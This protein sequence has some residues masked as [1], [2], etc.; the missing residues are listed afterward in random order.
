M[1]I[2]I[3]AACWAVVCVACQRDE[4][5]S[6]LHAWFVGLIA[7]GEKTV[8]KQKAWPVCCFARAS[9]SAQSV[10]EGLPKHVISQRGRWWSESVHNVMMSSECHDVW[11]PEERVLCEEGTLLCRRDSCV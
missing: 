7:C 4:T 1:N 6:T 8:P 10:G 2:Y 3:P 5:L 9:A 11:T